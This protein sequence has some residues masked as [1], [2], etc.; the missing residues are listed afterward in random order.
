MKRQWRVR[1]EPAIF[2]F[3]VQTARFTARLVLAVR[4]NIVDLHGTRF[5][6]RPPDGHPFT[7]KRWPDGRGWFP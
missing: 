2:Y 3:Q 4:A 1:W 6:F 5:P 7:P